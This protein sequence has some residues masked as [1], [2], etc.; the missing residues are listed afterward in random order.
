MATQQLTP[1]ED[2]AADSS[3]LGTTPRGIDG[4]NIV[5]YWMDQQGIAHS[6]EAVA[7]PEPAAASL[8]ALAAFSLVRRA[9]RRA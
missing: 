1:F 4:T 9:R 5:G 6:F 2:P 8:L 7:V 3:G